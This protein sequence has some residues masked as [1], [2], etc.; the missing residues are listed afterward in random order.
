MDEIEKICNEN[1][2]ILIEDS[3]E[4]L[5]SKFNDKNLGSFGLMSTFSTYFG[6]HISTIEGGMVCTNDDKIANILKAIRSHGWDRDMDE[7]ESKK[8]KKEHNVDSFNDLYTFYY[9]GF[10]VRSTDLQAFLGIEQLKKIERIAEKR[11]E[12]FNTYID[13]LDESLW[14]PIARKDSYVSSFAFPVIHKK[15]DKIVEELKNS[16]VENRPL[17][18]GSLGKQPYWYKRNGKT[19]LKNADLIHDYGMYL[20]NNHQMGVDEINTIC[21]IINR[22]CA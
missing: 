2:I 20:P 14:K 21:N 12:N 7:E 11:R 5:G 16:S 10:N 19:S 6:H 18:G 22:V 9:T 4:S 8:L 13:N 17:L 15:R 3:C 1:N